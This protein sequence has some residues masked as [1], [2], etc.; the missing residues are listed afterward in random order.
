MDRYINIYKVDII[1]LIRQ[2][3]PG[4][5]LQIGRLTLHSAVHM[6]M[7]VSV[8]MYSHILVQIYPYDSICIVLNMMGF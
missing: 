1:E 7:R 4:E 5:L 3:S 8:H 2:L 6:Y